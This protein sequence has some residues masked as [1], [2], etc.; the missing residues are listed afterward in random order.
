M[1]EVVVTETEGRQKAAQLGAIFVAA[2]AKTSCNVDYAFLAAATA[3]VDIRKQTQQNQPKSLVRV[4]E[5]LNIYFCYF[6]NQ[7]F[8]FQVSQGAAQVSLAQSRVSEP[9]SSCGNAC[10]R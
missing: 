8:I 1:N 4:L 5:N 2:S 3:L 9:Q 7:L 6:S 10:G